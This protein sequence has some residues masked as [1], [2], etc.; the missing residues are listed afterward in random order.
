MPIAHCEGAPP[1]TEKACEVACAADC[2][3]GSWS[4]WSP[5]SHSCATKNAEG[6]QSR[7]RTVL[8]YPGKGN[9]NFPLA[10]FSF[11]LMLMAFALCRAC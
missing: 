5:C 3:V 10:L 2:V 7:T 1:S 4:P 9:G 11:L 8:A 6:R